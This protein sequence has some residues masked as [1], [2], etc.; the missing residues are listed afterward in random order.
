[1]REYSF[2]Y[3]NGEELYGRVFGNSHIIENL[4]DMKVLQIKFTSEFT[5][6]SIVSY[7]C[8]CKDVEVIDLGEK[9]EDGAIEFYEVKIHRFS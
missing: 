6:S 3:N 4:G 2:R 5:D 9:S 1:M 7:E 8:Y